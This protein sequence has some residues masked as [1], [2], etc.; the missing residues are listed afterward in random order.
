LKLYQLCVKM[1]IN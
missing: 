1:K